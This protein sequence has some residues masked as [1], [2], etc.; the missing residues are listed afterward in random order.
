MKKRKKK[1]VEKPRLNHH[2]IF[3]EAP[4]DIVGPEAMLWGDAQWWPTKCSMRFTK[5]T[6]GD[7]RVGTEYEQ[8]VLMPF[9]PKW[10]VKV[11]K[12]IPNRMVRRDF[13]TGILE[14]YEVV[15]VGERSNG[16]RIDYEL[17]YKI[18]GLVNKILWLF[19]YRKKHDENMVLIL[20]A[21]KDH[22]M[23]ICKEKKGKELE[24]E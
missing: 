5:K 2:F 6:E 8:K 3:I 4:I 23:R 1:I 11:T 7:V 12:I 17:Y 24:G 18:R 10:I 21:L 14:G 22:V 20:N 15:R 13:K 9:G 16:T 19:I